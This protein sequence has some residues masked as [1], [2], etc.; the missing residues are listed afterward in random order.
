[1]FDFAWSELALIGV[2]ALILI[3]PKDLPVAI[4]AVTDM[5]KKARAMASEFRGHVDEMVREANLDE[6]RNSV[7]DLRNF[8]VNKI[9]EDHVDPDGTLRNALSDQP[10]SPGITAEV[11]Q[12]PPPGPPPVPQP[13]APA[14]DK[15]G[16]P[17]SFVPP[18]FSQPAAPPAFMPPGAKAPLPRV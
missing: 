10:S 17:P 13:F 8:D 15:A 3:G 9:V 4:K 18:Q 2:V 16:E 14:M 5:V 7:S 1:M 11:L 12:E 6:L